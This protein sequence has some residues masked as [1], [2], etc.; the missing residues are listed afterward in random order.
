[1][2]RNLERWGGHAAIA[3][4]VLWIFAITGFTLGEIEYQDPTRTSPVP[5]W[6]AAIALSIGAALIAVAIV[7][8]RNSFAERGGGALAKSGAIVALLGAL[9]A[10]VPLWP[11]IFFGPLLVSLGLI[12]LG[13]AS[14]RT[15]VMKGGWSWWLALGVVPALASGAL[16]DF[17]GGDGTNG[18]F[19]L[20]VVLGG[21]LVWLGTRMV[22]QQPSAMGSVEAAR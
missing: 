9:L 6:V 15:G 4:G 13:A 18:G 14:I 1:M 7:S 2:P 20:A 12:G 3:G 22:G 19:V 10:V 5:E 21:G 17:A 11:M 8:L 16:I